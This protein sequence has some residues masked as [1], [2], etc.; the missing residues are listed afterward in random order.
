MANGEGTKSATM[1]VKQTN[2]G[3]ETST[4]RKQRQTHE[5]TESRKLSGFND[6]NNLTKWLQS[7]A[8]SDQQPQNDGW[9]HFPVFFAINIKR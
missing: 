5:E 1:K 4:E 7:D 8:V 2:D 9:D 6:Q 3:T